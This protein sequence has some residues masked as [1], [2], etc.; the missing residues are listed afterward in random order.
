MTAEELK[1]KIR[2]WEYEAGESFNDYFSHDR[3]YNISW[4]FWLIGKGFIEHGNS[5]IEEHNKPGNDSHYVG[6]EE[7]YQIYP[8]YVGLNEYGDPKWMEDNYEKNVLLMAEFLLATSTYRKRLKEWA[9]DNNMTL[10]FE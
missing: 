2:E 6:Q 8:E 4:A 3:V 9:D 10:S 5:I 7:L 1:D